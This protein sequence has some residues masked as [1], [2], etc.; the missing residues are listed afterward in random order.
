MSSF[1][2]FQKSSWSA[3]TNQTYGINFHECYQWI[4]ERVQVPF[5]EVGLTLRSSTQLKKL[6]VQPLVYR[7]NG[8]S[9]QDYDGHLGFRLRYST[10]LSRPRS[11]F[12]QERERRRLSDPRIPWEPHSEESE[13]PSQRIRAVYLRSSVDLR[14]T[15]ASVLRDFECDRAV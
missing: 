12:N 13:L 15:E 1:L 4:K 7:L 11:F 5:A 8:L 2:I 10:G 6:S 14:L 3:D 9:K